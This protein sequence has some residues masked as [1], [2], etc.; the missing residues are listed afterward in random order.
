MQLMAGWSEDR[1]YGSRAAFQRGEPDEHNPNLVYLTC[2]AASNNG[3][4]EVARGESAKCEFSRISDLTSN[5]KALLSISEDF[6]LV[7]PAQDNTAYSAVS[8][9]LRELDPKDSSKFFSMRELQLHGYGDY[10]DDFFIKIKSETPEYYRVVS[11]WNAVLTVITEH[12]FVLL[13]SD[14]TYDRQ[15]ELNEH[16]ENLQPLTTLGSEVCYRKFLDTAHKLDD[17]DR[18]LV[19]DVVEDWNRDQYDPIVDDAKLEGMQTH[20]LCGSEA[21][22]REYFLHIYNVCHLDPRFKAESSE[23]VTIR[24]AT[25]TEPAHLETDSW[26]DCDCSE[27]M[28]RYYSE[29]VEHALTLNT[30]EGWSWEYNDG[31]FNRRSGY[32]MT[33]SRLE[34]VFSKP[35]EHEIL[36]SI[37]ILRRKCKEIG[38]ALPQHLQT[39]I[40]IIQQ[41]DT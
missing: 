34:F 27:F 2:F 3:L 38:V 11:S 6:D 19:A 37:N 13:P 28:E 7:V 40:E 18:N 24:A 14:V 10:P 35:S 21:E 32:D 33:A 16:T 26:Y 41:P 36:R 17:D 9:S 39:K 29:L 4:I 12:G 30:P 22:L 15:D 1:Y 31:A 20:F 5:A 25:D 8:F 23:Q